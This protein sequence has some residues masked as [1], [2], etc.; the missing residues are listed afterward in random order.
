MCHGKLRRFEE[1]AAEEERRMRLWDLVDRETRA[2]APPTPVA[3]R[4]D[5]PDFDPE[6]ILTGAGRPSHDGH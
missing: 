5:T 4:D 2:P 1:R 6:E 3:E